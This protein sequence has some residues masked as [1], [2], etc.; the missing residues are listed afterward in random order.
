MTA[1]GT[2]VIATA[3]ALTLLSAWLKLRDDR[4]TADPESVTDWLGLTSADVDAAFEE[5]PAYDDTGR[6][7]P[8][9]IAWLEARDLDEQ[10]EAWGGDAS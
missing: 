10:W 4:G 7:Y 6:K 2:A 9:V 5:T 3:V 1:V 8:A